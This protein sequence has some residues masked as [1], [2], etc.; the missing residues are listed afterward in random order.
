MQSLVTIRED[1]NEFDVC[2]FDIS[3]EEGILEDTKLEIFDVQN[4]LDTLVFS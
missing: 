3:Y 4:G 2:E 1:L